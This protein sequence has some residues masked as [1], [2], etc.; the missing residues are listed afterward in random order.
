MTSRDAAAAFR[1]ALLADTAPYAVYLVAARDALGTV[2]TLDFLSRANG[3][4]PS[5]QDEGWFARRDASPLD[6]RA[7][8]RDLGWV[9]QDDWPAIVASVSGATG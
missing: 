4:D 6:T 8:E 5:V 1:A 3:M 7:A 2:D 9:A